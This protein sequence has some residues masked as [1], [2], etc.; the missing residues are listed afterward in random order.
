MAAEVT[1]VAPFLVMLLVF[2]GVVI[3]RG[4][5]ARIRVDD[6]AHQAAR[7][8]SI[9]RSPAA[10]SAAAQSTAASALSSA[11][12]TCASLLVSAATGGL[13]PGGTVSVTVS[14]KVD[15]GD[16]LILGV[17]GGKTLSAT[18]VEP[19]DLW[20]STVNTGGQT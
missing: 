2:V 16:A 14:C 5:D 13:R 15:F 10:A 17:P 4:V 1:I 6:A 11:G 12:V 18:S 19:V 7:A 8:A 20:R 3:H 9:E